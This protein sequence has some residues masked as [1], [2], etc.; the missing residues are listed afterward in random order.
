MVPGSAFASQMMFSYEKYISVPKIFRVREYISC[1]IQDSTKK[2]GE[3]FIE[4][5]NEIF[6]I[7][8]EFFQVYIHTSA[9][10]NKALDT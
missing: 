4:E 10:A 5:I 2:I 1:K 7:N 3:L 9:E 8:A 6:D